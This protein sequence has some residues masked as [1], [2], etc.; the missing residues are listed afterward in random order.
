MANQ[1]RAEKWL[2]IVREDLSVGDLLFNNGH[3]LYTAYMCHQAIEKTLKAYWCVCRDDDPPFIHNHLRIAQ[4]CG[5]YTKMS[6]EQKDFLDEMV[7]MNIE[8]R[9]NEYKDAVAGILDREKTKQ[10]LE[11]TKQLYKWILQRDSE[12]TKLVHSSGDIKK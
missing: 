4:G 6:Q 5:L 8:A 10:T 3:W 11:K 2:R 9:Y 12:K 1:E 7:P